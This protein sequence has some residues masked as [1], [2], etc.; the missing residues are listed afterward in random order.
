MKNRDG[1]LL[2]ALLLLVAAAS[3]LLIQA[4][5]SVIYLHSAVAQNWAYYLEIFPSFAPPPLPPGAHCLDDCSPHH[6]AFAGWVG[7]VSLLLGILVLG[8]CWWRPKA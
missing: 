6:S 7:A 3:A 1:R 8:F 2:I 5:I 4:W